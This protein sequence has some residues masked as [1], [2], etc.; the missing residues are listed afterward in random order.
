MTERKSV[1]FIGIG[2][3]GLSAIARVLLESGYHV[4]GSDRTLSPLAKSL[5]A[6]GVRIDI[7]HRAENVG[8][9]QLVVR[10]SA[11]PDDNVEVL[12]AQKQGI[13]V[14]KRSEFLSSLMDEH[15]GIAVAGTHGKTTTTAMIAWMLTFLKQDPTFISGGVL[16]NLG[17]NAHA[18][19]G[20]ALVIEADE[21]DH[22]FLGL[23]PKL[24]V[25]TN[26]EHDHPDCYPTAD[27]FFKAFDEFASQVGSDGTLL[28]CTND[29]GAAQLGRIASERGQ[30]VFSYAI[31][32]SNNGSADQMADYLAD[33]LTTNQ[34]GGMSFI[35]R[36]TSAGRQFE[37]RPAINL[38]IPGKHNIQ[39]ALATLAVAHQMK[40]SVEQA[41]QAL[42]EFRGTGRRFEVRGEINRITV[43]DDYAHHPTEIRA[44]LSAAR[45]RYPKSKL[46]VVWQPHTYSRTRLLFNDFVAAFEQ[47]DHVVVTEIYAARE[48]QPDD[49]FSSRQVVAAMTYPDARYIP[50]FSQASTYLADRLM[51]GDV[52][53]VLS[54]GDADQIS[55]RV[56]ALLKERSEK[57]D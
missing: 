27:D 39:N 26:I 32:D 20:Q 7:G 57:S 35:A 18:G 29:R 22:M 9:T 19:K 37:L 17:T 5:Q 4:T 50:D 46:W 34:Y 14:L 42:S 24:A 36:C 3:T 33:T 13:P 11:V 10:S 51:P 38:L 55:T 31:R 8:D 41:S 6:D 48:K 12:A 45:M 56:E 52:L 43:I 30:K 47:A 40:L 2:G 15:F 25:I 28:V 54:A 16:N 49:G 21:Y 44:T 1:H 23:K 53:I